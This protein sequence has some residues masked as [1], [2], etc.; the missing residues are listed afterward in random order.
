[1]QLWLVWI[2]P[3]IHVGEQR[4][5]VARCAT[6]G[7]VEH[8]ARPSCGAVERLAAAHLVK[9]RRKILDMVKIEA[10]LSN[11]VAQCSE[12]PSIPCPVLKLLEATDN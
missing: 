9:L 2:G 11:A 1:M 12:K 6:R 7:T 4:L 10:V 8:P 3:I 5:R